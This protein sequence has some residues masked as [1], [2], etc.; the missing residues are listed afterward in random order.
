M[1]FITLYLYLDE[2][3]L[4]TTEIL[5]IIFSQTVLMI[6]YTNGD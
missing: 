5:I 1:L 3:Y 6:D 2:S 4:Y